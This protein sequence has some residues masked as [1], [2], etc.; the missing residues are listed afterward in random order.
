MIH[1]IESI[2]IEFHMYSHV[3]KIKKDLEYN[4]RGINKTVENDEHIKQNNCKSLW[5][6]PKLAIVR[7]VDFWIGLVSVFSLLYL[8]TVLL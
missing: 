2:K 7:W 1:C 8:N 6:V 3:V 4:R 5:R